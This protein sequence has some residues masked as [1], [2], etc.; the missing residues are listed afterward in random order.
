MSKILYHYGNS[1]CS[2]KVRLVLREKQ[3][4]DWQSQQ[5][6]LLRGEQFDPEYLKLNPKGV[7]PT[8]VDEYGVL[9]ESTLIAEYLDDRYPEPAL[10]PKVPHNVARMRLYSKACDEGLHQGVGAISYAGIFIDRLRPLPEQEARS[11]LA[12]VIDLERR[13]RQVSV[14]EDG[15]KAPAVYRGVVAYEKI[16]QKISRDLADGREW[17]VGD[18]FTLA[19]VNLAPYLARLEHMGLLDVWIAERPTV[20]EWFRR[21]QARPSYKIEV[22]D[23]ILESQREEMRNGGRR[24]RKNISEFRDHY[25]KSD[26]GAHYY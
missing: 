8:W 19:D 12:R 14:Y 5:V 4:N 10:K 20:A 26:F 15:V 9:T 22:I 16:F 21:I 13:D 11:N 7:V 25:L 23:W 3:V 1:V 24:I 18:Q 17:L 2:E 6:T